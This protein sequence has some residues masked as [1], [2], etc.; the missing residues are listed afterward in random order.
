MK[1]RIMDVSDLRKRIIRALDDARKDASS[2]RVVVDEAAKAYE[3]FLA[4]I[5]T[6]VM[7][8]A[9]LVLKAEGYSFAVQTPAATVRLVADASAQTFIEL[10]LDTSGSRAV[11]IG[12]VSLAR[13]R[14][15]HIIEE[16]PIADKL[17]GDVTEEDLSTFLV[18]EIPKLIVRS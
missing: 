2:R 6:P 12:R 11:V 4:D 16:R 8:Q 9:A 3:S 18:V 10:G 13:G 17:V 1:G 5:A 7:R 15:G 14:Q